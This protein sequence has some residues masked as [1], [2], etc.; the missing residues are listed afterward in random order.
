ML[1]CEKVPRASDLPSE[2]LLR[3][4][5]LLRRSQG[6]RAGHVR[7]ED[8]LRAGHLLPE[9]VLQGEEVPCPPDLPSEDLLPEVLLRR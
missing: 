1:P 9:K 3:S 6:L 2:D 8:L 7:S 5:R 4:G